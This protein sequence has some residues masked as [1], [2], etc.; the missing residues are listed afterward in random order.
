[1][2]NS[3]LLV[4]ILLM[5]F[6]ISCSETNSPHKTEEPFLVIPEHFP[7]L[8]IPADNPITREKVELGRMLF[9]EKLLSNDKTIPSCS[10]CMKQEH[11]FSDNTPVSL[12]N[13][14]LPESRNT[15]SLANVAYREKL[16]WDGR[17]KAIE[18]PAYR[19]MF[20]P[21]ILGA[22]T[23]EIV[24]RLES[25]PTYP[26]LFKKA[27]GTNAKPSAYLISKAIACFV[28]TLISGNSRYDKYL[29]GDSNA[30][31]ISEKRGMQ[32]FFS[33]R[34]NCSKC[35][36]GLFFT[37]LDFHNTGITTHYFDRGRYLITGENKDRGKFITP[38]LR[39]IEVTAPYMHDGSFPTLEKVIEHYNQGGK[40]FINKD[41]LIKPLGLTSEEIKDLIAFLKSLTDWEFIHNKKFSNP[42]SN[43]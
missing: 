14:N 32:L 11:A 12:G 20:L 9:Y 23:N 41:T 34:T 18:A 8:P 28:R 19:S 35:H 5:I 21:R 7:E 29:R 24:K 4:L 6:I 3:F 31:N 15:M 42:L 36:S 13:K 16:F 17:G 22:D 27:F 39:N 38:T 1:M 30:L 2:K 40:P 43:N 25:H 10:H 33:E 26:L 37:D